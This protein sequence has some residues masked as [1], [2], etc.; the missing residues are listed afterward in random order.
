M[1]SCSRK[2][3]NTISGDGTL[4]N[5]FG[6]A[7]WAFLCKSSLLAKIVTTDDGVVTIVS[8]QIIFDS[9]PRP[10]GWQTRAYIR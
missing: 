5:F 1:L 2:I 9:V 7:G 4:N 10:G 8:Y 6:N 3:P